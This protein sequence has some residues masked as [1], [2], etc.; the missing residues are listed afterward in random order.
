MGVLGAEVSPEGGAAS[1]TTK[2]PWRDEQLRERLNVLGRRSGLEK[3]LGLSR[4]HEDAQT[5][6]LGPP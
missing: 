3:M 5:F 6:F 1:K 2:C 4:P